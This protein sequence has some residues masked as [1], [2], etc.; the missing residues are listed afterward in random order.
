ML[1]LLKNTFLK[2]SNL[3]RDY[4]VI[5][6]SRENHPLDTPFCLWLRI[7]NFDTFFIKNEKIISL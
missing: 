7:F 5:T 3:P 1:S 6:V 2:Q 4:T